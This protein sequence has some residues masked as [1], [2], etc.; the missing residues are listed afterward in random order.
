MA[1]DS[2]IRLKRL[3][4]MAFDRYNNKESFT[5]QEVNAYLECLKESFGENEASGFLNL[6]LQTIK[7]HSNENL[8]N[9]FGLAVVTTIAEQANA[10]K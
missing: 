2:K 1:E 7:D 5:S 3:T 9:D 6:V 4:L 8:S 10:K